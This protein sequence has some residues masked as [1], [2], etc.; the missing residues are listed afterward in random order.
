[1]TDS[2]TV[3]VWLPSSTSS[4]IP[5]TVTVCGLSQF[6]EVNVNDDAETDASPV[7]LLA[8]SMTTSDDGSPV[9]TTVNVCVDPVS[10]TV[11]DVSDT[12]KP[13]VPQSAW[14]TFSWSLVSVR[15]VV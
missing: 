13:G 6:D 7:S 1:L 15:V 5:V 12:V 14:A 3:E 8:T 11:R 2:V 4:L 9:S 10:A